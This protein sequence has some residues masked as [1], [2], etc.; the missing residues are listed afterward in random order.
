MRSRTFL[1]A[2][3]LVPCLALTAMPA[4][5]DMI[6]TPQLLAPSAA[7]AQGA[8]VAAFLEREDV[9]RQLEAQG[10]SPADA[11]TRVASL[12]AAELQA[13]SSGIDSLPAGAGVSTLGLILIIVLIVVLL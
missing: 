11:A 10:V 9:Q 7:D 2:A 12:T 3:L 8:T 5:A 4:R 13:L 6:G 1:A